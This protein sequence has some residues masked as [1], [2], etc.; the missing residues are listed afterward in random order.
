MKRAPEPLVVSVGL[1]DPTRL[2]DR[3]VGGGGRFEPELPEAAPLAVLNLTATLL[4][5]S[6]TMTTLK[7]SYQQERRA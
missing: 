2:G 5:S 4:P 1:G 7:G 3:R 6:D